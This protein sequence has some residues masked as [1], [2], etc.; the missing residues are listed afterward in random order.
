MSF[1]WN[2][3]VSEF[4]VIFFFPLSHP[5]TYLG[6][7]SAISNGD[8]DKTCDANFLSAFSLSIYAPTNAKDFLGF[9]IPFVMR[10]DFA[11]LI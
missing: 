5:S 6:V 4:V 3:H 9:G 1:S 10:D 11:S 2:L 8:V 7:I